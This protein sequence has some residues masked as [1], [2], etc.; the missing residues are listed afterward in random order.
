MLTILTSLINAIQPLLVPI[1]FITAWGL[2]FLVISSLYSAASHSVTIAK[3]MHQIPCCNCQ[4]FTADY[5][6]KCTVHPS[7]A[8]TEAAISC[9]DYSAKTNPMLY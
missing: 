8:N 3:Q 2:I 1:C 9:T 6:L 7:I 5:R 4:F